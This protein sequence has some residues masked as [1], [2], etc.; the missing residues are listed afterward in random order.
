MNVDT[1]LRQ[2]GLERYAKRFA[3]GEITWPV[4]PRL[5]D[6]DL[7]ELG[8]PLGPRKILLDAI[9]ALRD[10]REAAPEAGEAAAAPVP[11]AHE[12]ERRH[13]T[14]MFVDLADSTALS[15]AHDA[16]DVLQSLRRYQDN[17]AAAI[18]QRGGYLA[19]YMGDGILAYFGY[20]QAREDAAE[21]AV[22]AAL[23]IVTAVR[24][25]PDLHGHRFAVRIG[26]ASG[27]VVVGD[28]VGE[29]VAREI[30]VVGRT[31]NLAS[32]LLAVTPADGVVVADTTRRLLGG[33]F[34]YRDLGPQ[35]FKGLPEPVTA[36]EVLGER[37]GVS[38]FEAA[39]SMW[40]NTFVGRTREL[41][42]LRG[43][44]RQAVAGDGNMV[45]VSGEAGMGK[46]RLC[47]AF[48]EHRAATSHL[49][50]QYQCSSQ[51]VNTPL[52]PVAGQLRHA[53]GID[54]ADSPAEAYGKLARFLAAG[55]ITD[56]RARLIAPLLGIEVEGDGGGTGLP[57]SERRD[58][59]LATL[60]DFIE[61]LSRTQPIFLLVED[62]H[63]ID[64]TTQE[65]V[66]RAVARLADWPVLA[67]V[68]FRPDYQPK[69]SGD[70]VA[71]RLALNRLTRAQVA[72]MLRLL[73]AGKALPNAAVEHIVGKTDGVPLFV[74][75]MFRGLKET[76]FLVEDGESFRLARP[77]DAGA[78]PATLQDSLMARLDR[79]ASVKTVAQVAA[80]IGRKF[81]G[82]L[83]AAALEMA[84]DECLAA[85]D[86]LV[87]QQ[88]VVRRGG[89]R[90]DS[91]SFRHALIRDAGYNSLLR[92]QRQQWHARIVGAL[93]RTEPATVATQPELVA[94]HHQESG[95]VEAALKH[96]SAAAELAERRTAPRE[97]AQ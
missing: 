34:R 53:A 77:L 28:V 60:L 52:H 9:A 86:Q 33:L 29:E 94:R 31:P 2:L 24:A 17:A 11:A 70:V 59:L 69:W 25:M 75:E 7:R 15:A 55:G 41:E 5:T 54:G 65:L 74:E 81:S 51:H 92:R 89:A 38:R 10:S 44:W 78:V 85:L 36:Y 26:I 84:D 95:N 97:A 39:R 20:P 57:P 40:R 49:R 72:S 4:V 1:W 90:R 6:A 8:L 61:G 63:W 93:E 13:L 3:A 68:T 35:A 46:S 47:D 50:I 96:W 56:P 91:Y 62:A 73:A 21:R 23:D 19:K 32:R 14:V 64:P 42:V 16:E 80:V 58:R 45:L 30:N 27:P 82:R 76:G 22:H 12:S 18:S 66:D 88:L 48:G 83:L 67:V 37:R 79:L 71:A 87:K 43:Q